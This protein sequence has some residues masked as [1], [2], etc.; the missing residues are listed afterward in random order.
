MLFG[1]SQILLAL[2]RLADEAHHEEIIDATL[3]VNAL[4]VSNGKPS[5]LSNEHFSGS[6]DSLS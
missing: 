4:G 2:G 6:S 3:G 5:L 1:Q